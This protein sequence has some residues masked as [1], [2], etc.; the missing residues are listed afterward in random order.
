MQGIDGH[1]ARGQTPGKLLGIQRCSQF[2][3]AMERERIIEALTAEIV[4][5]DSLCRRPLDARIA[6]HDHDP[7]GTAANRTGQAIDQREMCEVID[8]KLELDP[9][10][11]QQG[12][13]IRDPRVRDDGI[14]RTGKAEYGIGRL[15]HRFKIRQVARDRRGRRTNGLACRL[16]TVARPRQPDDMRAIGGERVHGLKSDARVASGY[17]DSLAG[18]IDAGQDLIGRG[19]G[20]MVN[21]WSHARCL[22]QISQGTACPAFTSGDFFSPSSGAFRSLSSG[23]FRS[24]SSSGITVSGIFPLC[25]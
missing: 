13:R 9:V 18:Q 10:A 23:G 3:L 15:F 8:E 1:A 19:A 4:E 11:C 20:T 12:G 6:A 5:H 24:L 14:Q 7:P 16:S 22:S 21:Q 25:I 17:H 2:R